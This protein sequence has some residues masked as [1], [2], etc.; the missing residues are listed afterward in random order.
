[1][2]D[3]NDLLMSIK[4][5]ATE[6]VEA[7]QP[8]DFCFGKVTSVEPLKIAVEQKMVLSSAQLVLTRNVT[9][10]NVEMTVNHTTDTVDLQ[11]THG[12][13]GNTDTFSGSTEIGGNDD[14]HNHKYAHL[15]S[16]SGNTENSNVTL[17]HRHN[18]AG[19]KTFIVHNG[20]KQGDEVV[21]LKQKGGQK[22]L[23]LD[24]VVNI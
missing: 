13:N 7:G 12:V 6:A 16:F 20:L 18:Y 4:K 21:L 1:M 23:V 15:H 19:R 24:R 9:D 11:H 17:N 8:S 3:S 14:P 2:L 22:Y 5:A 10:Y